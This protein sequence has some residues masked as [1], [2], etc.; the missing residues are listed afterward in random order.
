M[1]NQT[2]I[3]QLHQEIDSVMKEI[4]DFDAKI[5]ERNTQRLLLVE[6]LRDLLPKDQF[7]RFEQIINKTVEAVKPV[8]DSSYLSPLEIDESNPLE[9]LRKLRCQIAQE[10]CTVMGVD[11]PKS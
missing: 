9:S 7:E 11:T 2:E 8:P 10:V 1:E 5:E 4:H 6:Q 3:A